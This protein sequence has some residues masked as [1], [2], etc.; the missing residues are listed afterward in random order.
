MA[1]RVYAAHKDPRQ[2]RKIGF[3]L[4]R[5]LRIGIAERDDLSGVCEAICGLKERPRGRIGE[6]G[7]PSGSKG[8]FDLTF[9][10]AETTPLVHADGDL[11]WL[12][13]C[14]SLLADEAAS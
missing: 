4:R 13:R 5:E 8:R 14:G 11:P 12:R 7:A 9:V 1:Q 10:E 6:F 3:A 2:R